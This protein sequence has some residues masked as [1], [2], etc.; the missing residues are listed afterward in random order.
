MG[1]ILTAFVREHAPWPPTR[2]GQ[3]FVHLPLHDVPQLQ[4]RA[5]DIQ[6][7]VTVLCRSANPGW[8]QAIEA[9]DSGI[10]SAVLPDLTATDLRRADLQLGELTGVKLT[11]AHLGKA[12]LTGRNLL[13]L[14]SKRRTC[15]TRPSAERPWPTPICNGP[16]SAKRISVKPT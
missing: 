9:L 16:T 8:L 5:A 1:E 12:D 15:A 10:R 13:E 11:A 7:A 4:L 6:A 3:H 14:T 2:P